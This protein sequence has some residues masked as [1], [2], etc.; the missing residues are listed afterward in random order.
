MRAVRQRV[1]CLLGRIV[2]RALV[3]SICAAAIVL[4]VGVPPALAQTV[5]ISVR[6]EKIVAL[7][8]ANWTSPADFFARIS[9]D[10]KSIQTPVVLNQNDISPNWEY[11]EIAVGGG[12][13]RI[14]IEVLDEDVTFNDPIDV[15]PQAGKRELDLTI[16]T[17]ALPCVVAGDV[18]GS[19]NSSIIS[20]GSES[21]RASLQFRID[22][23]IIDEDVKQSVLRRQKKT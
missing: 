5:Q 15:N 21:G 17:S 20:A 12:V 2:S 22:A 9:I 16:D 11:R 6:I 8:V 13:R 18:T 23:R 3:V 4:I 10:G 14:R 7:D 19:C 1:F